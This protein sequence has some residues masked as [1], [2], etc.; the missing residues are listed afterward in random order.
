MPAMEFTFSAED[1]LFSDSVRTW[2]AEH[3]VGEFAA[4]GS[5]S[6]MGEGAELDVRKA[7]ERELADGGWVGMGGRSSAAGATCRCCSR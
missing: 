1:E 3:L 2:M 7:W 4:L 6:N 5:G